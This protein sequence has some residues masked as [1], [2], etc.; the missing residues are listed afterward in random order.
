LGVTTGLAIDVALQRLG[1]DI[2][3]TIDDIRSARRVLARQ[4]HPDVGGSEEAM[5]QLNEAVD[6]AVR[7]VREQRLD[8]SSDVSPGA[9]SADHS[10]RRAPATSTNGP[11][12]TS[13]RWQRAASGGGWASRDEPSFTIDVL[14]APAFE[15]LLIVS[16][17]YGDVIDDDPPYRLDVHLFDPSE[18]VARLTLIPEAGSSSVSIHVLSMAGALGPPPTAEAVRDLFVDGLNRLGS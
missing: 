12:R 6:V 16:C 13:P 4:A 8:V 15:A 7:F 10:D 3:A 5:R 11:R 18:C 2:S 9:S 1:L 17:W 14:P